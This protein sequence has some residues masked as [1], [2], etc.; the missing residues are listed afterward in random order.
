MSSRTTLVLIGV[1]AFILLASPAHAFGAGNIA[2]VSAIEGHNW[3]HGDIEDILKTVACL[4]GHK[5]TSMMIKRV[6]F[7][8]WLRDY[9]Q[10]VDVGTLKGVQADTIRILVWV[11]AFMSFGYATEEFEVT[12]DRLGCYR[13]EEHIDNPK[14]YADNKDAREFDKRLRG[15]V[16]PVELEIDHDTG[17]KN[18]IANERAI[19]R[20]QL[21]TSS[22]VL[23]VAFTSAD[24]TPVE[25][26]AAE[27]R[28]FDFGAH[29]N[30]TELA[31]RELGFN[32][33]FPHVGAR[34]EINLRGKRVFP[35]VTG[36][37]GGVDFLHS[38]LGEATDHVT[39]SEVQQVDDALTQAASGSTSG[40]RG[41]GDSS[42][43]GLSGLTDLLSQV[44][45]TS[46]LIQ[47]AMELQRAS[48]S[49]EQENSR[50]MSTGYDDNY[51]SSRAEPSSMFGGASK[52]SGVN[53]NVDPQEAIKKI[54]PLLAFRDK[55]V[56]TIAGIVSKIPGLEKIIETISERVTL[57]IMGLL[58]PYMKP[59][60]AAASNGLK[61]GSSTVVSA[62]AKQQYLV[63]EDPS[64]SDPTHSMLSKDHFSNIL[65]EPAGE[66]AAA[67]LQYVAPRIVYAWDRPD[68]AENEVL[69]DIVR[70]F[71]HP[72]IRDQNLEVHRNMF[73]VVERWVN[74][75]SDRGRGLNEKLSSES[76]K[77]GKNHMVP[78][79][80]GMPA[81]PGGLG[82]SATA[83]GP[84]AMFGTSRSI[85]LGGLENTQGM[86]STYDQSPYNHHDQPY[87]QQQSGYSEPTGGYSGGYNQSESYGQQQEYQQSYGSS[88][89]GGYGQQPYQGG[90]YQGG[91]DQNQYGPGQGG[92]SNYR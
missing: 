71:H 44:P 62:S 60:I 37:F 40:Q 9:S 27:R 73:S 48:Q 7:G 35:L 26:S 28:T 5:W 34:T 36:T 29:T 88:S 66:V 42:G 89:Q 47:E 25:H 23:L 57:F 22:G 69:D 49:Q 33:V 1:L 81:L 59:I 30:Y 15:P 78:K 77:A 39:Q 55:V 82:H 3:R 19:G 86:E 11:L 45:G 90:G 41:F 46:G 8:N 74:S 54:Y 38:V 50:G 53:V 24:C 64:S 87:G 80:E 32:G 14:D 85:D 10:A 4:K 83:G 31:L 16:Q 91:Y 18:Y 52:I 12:A 63:W 6:Y 65:N 21:A 2:S 61:T 67:I 43:S 13:P 76:V 56:R 58:A 20:H 70:V 84:L 17:M 72:A 75:R 51:S 79:M 68:V 92:Y